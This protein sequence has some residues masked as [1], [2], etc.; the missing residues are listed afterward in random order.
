MLSSCLLLRPERGTGTFTSPGS[1]QDGI[2]LL[3]SQRL[4]MLLERAP[5]PE[6]HS[7]QKSEGSEHSKGLGTPEDRL[8]ANRQVGPVWGSLCLGSDQRLSLHQSTGSGW[9]RKFILCE[10]P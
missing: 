3:R 1:V 10:K 2:F 9:A 7:L 5:F 8:S 6:F 4:P